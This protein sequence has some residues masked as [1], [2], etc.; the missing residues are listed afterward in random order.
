MGVRLVRGWFDG[1]VRVLVFVLGRLFLEDGKVNLNGWDDA[2]ARWLGF[3]GQTYLSSHKLHTPV[4]VKYDDP[5]W[6][7]LA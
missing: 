6:G 5:K 4:L 3:V 2:M 7:Q 1:M